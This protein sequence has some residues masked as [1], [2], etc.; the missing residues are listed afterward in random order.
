MRNS[1]SRMGMVVVLAFLGV[2]AFDTPG[3][4]VHREV[5]GTLI[6]IGHAVRHLPVNI[7]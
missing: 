5:L 2:A 3:N 1:L 6:Q 7:F 4:F